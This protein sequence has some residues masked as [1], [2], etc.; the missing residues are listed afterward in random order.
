MLVLSLASFIVSRPNG[1]EVLEQLR[2][3]VER[4][5]MLPHFSEGLASSGSSKSLNSSDESSNELNRLMNES[6]SPI[7]SVDSYEALLHPILSEILQILKSQESSGPKPK[8]KD[9]SGQVVF[10]GMALSSYWV[11]CYGLDLLPDPHRTILLYSD[12][13]I[14]SS[15][16]GPLPEVNTLQQDRAELI[17]RAL[18]L[19]PDL[20]GQL[21]GPT[22]GCLVD[23]GKVANTPP[24]E[25]GVCP[26]LIRS[27]E[28]V[29]VYQ[30]RVLYSNGSSAISVKKP[31]L[32]QVAL[33]ETALSAAGVLGKGVE[34]AKPKS[35]WNNQ[36]LLSAA[37]ALFTLIGV[38]TRIMSMLNSQ[39]MAAGKALLNVWE[40]V[41]DRLWLLLGN[42]M[43]NVSTLLQ[44][45]D[46]STFG[47]LRSL[48]TVKPQNLLTFNSWV[49]LF[50]HTIFTNAVDGMKRLLIAYR[51]QYTQIADRHTVEVSQRSIRCASDS[52]P[53]SQR[54]SEEMGSTVIASV[55][56][57]EKDAMFSIIERE[58]NGLKIMKK[59]WR[60][61]ILGPSMWHGVEGSEGSEGDESRRVYY[62]LDRKETE[63]RLRNRLKR[64]WHERPH[65]HI[66]R[67]LTGKKKSTSE[68]E[69]LMSLR[70]YR[71]GSFLSVASHVGDAERLPSDQEE[72][73]TPQS[74]MPLNVEEEVGNLELKFTHGERVLH[75]SRMELVLPMCV[76][77]GRADLTPQHLFFFPESF[78]DGHEGSR[79]D[80]RVRKWELDEITEIYRR[81]YLLCPTAIEIMA[82]N[83]SYFLNFPEPGEYLKVFQI[84]MAQKPRYLYSHPLFRH[85]YPPVQLVAKAEWTQLW[86]TRQLSN[87]EYLMRLN[88]AAGRSYNDI[89]QYPVFPWLIADYTS[90]SLDL[91]KPE[92]YR[93][94]S[95]PIGALNPER[96]EGFMERYNAMDEDGAIPR[97]MYGSHYSN[98]GTVLNY[99]VRLEPFAEYAARLQGGH[100]DWADRLFHSIEE[101][102]T[103]VLT[104]TGDVK[105]LTP[106]FFYSPHFLR[107]SNGL[108]LGVRQDGTKLDDV[109]L[110]PW[111]SSPEEFVRI[112]MQALESDYVSE[113]LSDW[114]DLIFGCV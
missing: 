113:R 51:N 34:V 19:W 50:T 110:P 45:L 26:V 47:V 93:D 70:L 36:L 83:R 72:M 20:A 18:D 94:L 107:N 49:P 60:E 58:T 112:N 65:R 114:I 46:E 64:D 29:C 37:H 78:E 21:T 67:D 4:Q 76:I 55:E 27:I 100:F 42:C 23:G 30:M 102:W 79:K 33:L 90:A 80:M 12:E 71:R 54:L 17:Q 62:Q 38:C 84:M 2:M 59:L 57:F 104:S 86:R 75:S 52:S 101:A 109:V 108:D 5:V 3:A 106:E 16:R 63:K 66:G 13:S 85:L 40:E 103:R 82:C 69:T 6:S 35:D 96:L 31:L 22:D 61:L 7:L 91:D 10:E 44:T 77:Q 98:V 32:E 97:F 28:A 24:I 89:Q 81:R 41:S 8:R 48:E 92:V 87:F 11:M 53:L 1:W 25:K 9:P 111:A 73:T 56:A 88:M 43:R 99:L 74:P 15:S 68:E 39:N 105:E 95:K 14:T